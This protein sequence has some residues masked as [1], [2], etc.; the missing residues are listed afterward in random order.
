MWEH[1]VFT[2][3]SADQ[4]QMP[5]NAIRNRAGIQIDVAIGHSPPKFPDD[6]NFS[7]PVG[8]IVWLPFLVC[9]IWISTVVYSLFSMLIFI[10]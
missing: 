10:L 2:L 9:N 4:D 1:T 3:I 6:Q 8:Y 5:Q 7:D